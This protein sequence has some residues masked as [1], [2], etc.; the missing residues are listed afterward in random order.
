MVKDLVVSVTFDA[1]FR[2][3]LSR[4]APVPD[5]VAEATLRI[6]LAVRSL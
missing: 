5:L 6:I 3:M 4:K 2:L 1:E